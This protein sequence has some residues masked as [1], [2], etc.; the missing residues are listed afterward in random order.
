M[1]KHGPEYNDRF[2]I[3]TRLFTNIESCLQ[4]HENRT[5]CEKS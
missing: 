5:F 4:F 3:I 1:Y 2:K